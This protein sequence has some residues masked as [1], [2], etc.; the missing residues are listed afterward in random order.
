MMREMEQKDEPMSQF[1]QRASVMMQYLVKDTILGKWL[2]YI[3]G[4]ISISPDAY[5]TERA[6]ANAM[7]LC[8]CRLATAIIG[9]NVIFFVPFDLLYLWDY[10][11]KLLILLVWRSLFAPYT[12]LLWRWALRQN[13][14]DF[15]L[16]YWGIHGVIGTF[17]GVVATMLLG[18][19][20]EPWF[21]GAVLIPAVTTL[22]VI[23]F[24]KRI[25]LT[26]SITGACV[27]AVLAVS[28]EAFLYSFFPT[29]MTYFGLSAGMTILSGELYS[30]KV[31]E[32]FGRSL[33]IRKDN[34][35]L[36]LLVEERTRQMTDAMLEAEAVQEDIRREVSRE[37]HDELGHLIV[38]HNLSLH[39]FRSKHKENSEFF[40][41]SQTFL[42]ELQDIEKATRQTISTLR[43]NLA[44]LPPFEQSLEAWLGA[45]SERTGIEVEWLVEPEGMELEDKV[46]FV[47]SR[48][49][50]KVMSDI[51]QKAKATKAE[52]ILLEEV[53]CIVL[54]IRDN[55][56]DARS[57]SFHQNPVFS[58]IPERIAS[59][60]GTY[61][62]QV[63]AKKGT[64]IQLRVPIKTA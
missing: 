45:Y 37:L 13:P 52:V 26:F 24:H 15:K 10:P 28:P 18:S 4:W 16:F 55:G 51:E 31:R 59:I 21:H 35:N 63:N 34:A 56:K 25:I 22:F 61:E 6:Y 42:S 64:E 19:F 58:G 11:E 7:N 40:Q 5:E 36:S 41:A 17:L 29:Y 48:V 1:E 23:E 27:F 49:I 43:S 47:M 8:Y 20:S 9:I 54:S 44:L 33:K 32:N 62:I 3:A 38:L 53:D 39:R 14:N 2:F 60:N 57:F 30:L 12:F 50:Q 46:A